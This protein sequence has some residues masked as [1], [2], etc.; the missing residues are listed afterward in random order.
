MAGEGVAVKCSATWREDDGET[1]A[2]ELELGHAGDHQWRNVIVTQ[3]P[4]TSNVTRGWGF[5][6]ASKRSHYFVAFRSLCGRWAYVGEL[7]ARPNTVS[8]DDCAACT[9]RLAAS[10]PKAGLP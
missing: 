8:P 10:T 4:A 6:R 9:K 5:P 7:E 3:P 2:C 1:A